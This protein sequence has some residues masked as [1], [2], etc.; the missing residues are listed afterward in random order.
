MP[1]V[2]R[3]H[4]P[5]T[6]TTICGKASV[7]C[8]GIRGKKNW[9]I[10]RKQ[11]ETFNKIFS[12]LPRGISRVWMPIPTNANA[13]IAPSF[14]FSE[15]ISR[16]KTII[17]GKCFADGAVIQSGEAFAIT[18][19]D[20]HTCVMWDRKN[21]DCTVCFHAARD[22]LFD[23][24]RLLNRRSS[25]KHDSVIDAA[26]DIFRNR[27]ILPRDIRIF[28]F[29]GIRTGFLHPA[30]HP[31][32]G[33]YNQRLLEECANY[34]FAI[35]DRRSGELDMHAVIAGQA[36]ERGVPKSQIASDGI[37]TYREYT[38]SGEFCWA[39]ARRSSDNKTTLKQRNLVLVHRY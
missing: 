3:L 32:Y 22:S 34:P 17:M 4:E 24:E 1:Q 38:A 36:I 5:L 2:V 27:G 30:N 25:R 21:K 9:A 33:K 35:I 6:S 13:E 20:C 28:T 19:A 39:S 15:E 8:Y 18:S 31:E 14:A 10:D 37:D 23:R 26:L 12:I 16:F 11:P 7:D 29:C